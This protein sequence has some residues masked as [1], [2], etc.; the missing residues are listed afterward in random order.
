MTYNVSMGGTLNSTILYYTIFYTCFYFAAFWHNKRLIDNA[1]KLKY[2][3]IL[4]AK[5]YTQILT[6]KTNHK[7][8]QYRN[9][10][11]II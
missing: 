1:I 6:L 4:N 8:N 11:Q 9:Q 7:I 3:A 2:N 10:N 5:Y